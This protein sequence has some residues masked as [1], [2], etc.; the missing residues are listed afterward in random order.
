MPLISQLPSVVAGDPSHRGFPDVGKP[1]R[2]DL[3]SI[4]YGDK[5]VPLDEVHSSLNVDAPILADYLITGRVW[6]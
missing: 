4:S 2:A 5:Y 3:T 6:P 1:F